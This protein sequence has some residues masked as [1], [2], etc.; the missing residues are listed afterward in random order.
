LAWIRAKV[1][2]KKTRRSHK[3]KDNGQK[4]R[5]Q[6]LY[7]AASKGRPSSASG[8]D[9]KAEPRKVSTTTAKRMARQSV[10]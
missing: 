9:T 2:R 5:W 3:P 10:A 6:L 4:P 7:E 8:D 1:E